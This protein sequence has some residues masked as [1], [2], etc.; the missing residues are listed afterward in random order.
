MTLK[1]AYSYSV[2]FLGANGVDEAEFKALC[3]VCSLAGVKNSEY[4]QNKSSDAVLT[5]PLADA[6]WRLKS[7][8]PLQYVLGSW[9][10]YESEFSVGSGVLIPRPET[11]ELTDI[12]V[13]AARVLESPTVLDLCAGS[14]CIGISIAR[15]VKNARVTA[16]ENSEKAFEYLKKNAAGIDNISLLKADVLNESAAASFPKESADIIVSNPPYIP[17]ADIDKLQR[18]VLFEPREALDGGEDG[19]LFYRSIACVWRNTLKSGGIL[20]FEIGE[21]QGASV[22]SILKSAGYVNIE[23]KKDI[24]GNDRMV[25]AEK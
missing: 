7:G 20:L 22:C 12:A 24:Y 4:E 6:L 14:G 11:E 16:V 8:E 2:Y 19:L 15:A 17:S 18:E 1:D 10:F 9:D 23:L 21:E 5:K 13:N 25:S 3:L